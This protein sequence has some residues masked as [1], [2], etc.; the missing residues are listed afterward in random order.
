[1][2]TLKEIALFIRS[3]GFRH[4]WRILSYTLQKSRLDRQHWRALGIKSPDEAPAAFAQSPRKLLEARPIPGGA[5]FRFARRFSEARLEIQ[6]LAPDLARVSWL[7]GASPIPYA[8]AKVDWPEVETQLDPNSQGWVLSSPELQIAIKSNGSLNFCTP[9]GKLLR[10][11]LPPIFEDN[12]RS[13]H[14]AQLAPDERM[15]GLGEQAAHLDLSGGNF[16]LWNTDAGGSYA[17]GAD[18][19]YAPIPVYLGLHSEGSYLV[20]YENPYRSTFKFSPAPVEAVASERNIQNAP[21]PDRLAEAYF[22]GGMLRYYFIPGPPERALERY[23]ELTGRPELPPRWSLG[24]HQ[25]RWGYK[26]ESDIREVAAGFREHAMPVSA[27]HLDIDYM[28]GYRVFTI[29]SQRFPD[30]QGLSRELAAQ[31]IRLVSILD[32]GVKQDPVYSVY[33]EGLQKKLFCTLPDG[34]P[35]IGLVWPGWTAYP[36]F[37][38]PEAR[39]WWGNKYAHLLEAGIAGF[40]HDMNEPTSFAAWGD[41]TLPLATQHDLEGVGGDHLQCH[42]LY[43]LQM[44]R[45][46]YEGL[47]QINPDRRP[48]I[49]SRAGWAGQQRFA[50]NWTGD[51]ESSWGALRT[52]IATV[53]GMGLSGLPYTG[54]DIGG[55]SGSPSAELYLRWFQMAAFLPFFRTHSS[56]GTAR[57]EPWVY[58][59]PYTSILREFL[60]LRERLEPYLYTLAWE[61]SLTGHP[62]VRPLFWNQEHLI[63]LWNVED[64]FLLGDSLLVAPILEENQVER[65]VVLPPGVWFSL[66][67][68]SPY[69]GPATVSLPVSLERIP[70]L[71]RSGSVIPLQQDQTISLHVYGPSNG[72]ASP[73]GRL[74]SDAGDGYPNAPQDWRVDHFYLLNEDERLVLNWDSEGEYPLPGAGVQ[75]ILHG[76]NARRAWVDGK[77]TSVKGNVVHAAPFKR[78]LFKI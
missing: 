72:Q 27:I 6:F 19:L 45:A 55:H 16:H 70:V 7:P 56:L 78:L 17:P 8:L 75:V 49:V 73:A 39:R 38:N 44:N 69:E 65:Q 57:R 15:M 67:D 12:G 53:L 41:L 4:S 29:D 3:N 66:W 63:N 30:I 28:D 11:D 26:T 50:W 46:G 31:G 25:C 35:L 34:N 62:L 40:W 68:D 32:P 36:D 47:R 77:G 60:R 10:S 5:L 76:L 54:P 61:A 52:T 43:A 22:A 51:T 59:E 9:D 33:R 58:G 13:F 23:T 20:F 74:Y 48:W 64:A 37:T 21:Q 2:A 14:R 71:V 18:P 42:N 1:M 24:Y